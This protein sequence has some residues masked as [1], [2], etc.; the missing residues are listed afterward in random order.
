[1]NPPRWSETLLRLLLID[2]DRETVSGDLLEEYRE[3]AVPTRGPAG[4]RWWYRRQVASF[5]DGWR[6]LVARDNESG[7][8]SLRLYANYEYVRLTPMM[9]AIGATAG[10]LSGALG[11]FV[12]A[13]ARVA[14][15]R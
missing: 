2:R 11:A 10:S 9:L 7:F 6:N 15:P 5:R 8:R 13:I 3:V 4:G 1:M 14:R 12:T